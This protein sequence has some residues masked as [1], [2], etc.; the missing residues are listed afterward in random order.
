MPSATI[1]TTVA[2]GMRSPR[3]QGTPPILAGSTEMRVNLIGR[4][5]PASSA[6]GAAQLNELRVLHVAV[7]AADGD[8]Q[9]S[10]QAVEEAQAHEV[11]LDEAHHRREEEV[12]H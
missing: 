9:Q 4:I 2:T 5:L 7:H 3:M 8:V 6:L 10:R 11:E 12:E 1:A